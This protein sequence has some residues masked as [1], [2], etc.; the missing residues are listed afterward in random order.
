[1]G[2]FT[3]AGDGNRQEMQKCRHERGDLC[4]SSE[5]GKLVNELV[6]LFELY[7]KAQLRNALL[8]APSIT[9]HIVPASQLTRLE[10][11]PPQITPA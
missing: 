8:F 5:V 3:Y 11:Y 9:L 7:K 1:M 4:N 10:P 6:E 2:V